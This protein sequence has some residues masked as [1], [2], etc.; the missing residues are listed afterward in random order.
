MSTNLTDKGNLGR[1]MSHSVLMAAHRQNIHDIA[2]KSYL[3][4]GTTVHSKA[5]R[6]Y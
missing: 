1:Q 2:A 3:L 6:S 5:D 4:F